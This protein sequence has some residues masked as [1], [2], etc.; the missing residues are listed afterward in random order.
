MKSLNV[1]QTR[2]QSTARGETPL[3]GVSAP[4]VRLSS[5]PFPTGET[6]EWVGINNQVRLKP[7]S[8]DAD[9]LVCK[10]QGDFGIRKVKVKKNMNSSR[11]LPMSCK[12]SEVKSKTS[13]LVRKIKDSKSAKLGCDRGEEVVRPPWTC[14]MSGQ[15]AARC[16]HRE[17]HPVRLGVSESTAGEKCSPVC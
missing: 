15:R 17:S 16:F 7:C 2:S 11:S 12:D 3:I 1:P 14:E 6:E 10:S 13:W 8:K 5:R 9:S 4:A